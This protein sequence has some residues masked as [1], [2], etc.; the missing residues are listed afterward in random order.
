MLS[1]IKVQN[2][3]IMELALYKCL[4]IVT[5]CECLSFMNTNFLETRNAINKEFIE[6]NKKKLLTHL[7]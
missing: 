5:I 2:V 1:E 7:C 6:K 4:K 3:L